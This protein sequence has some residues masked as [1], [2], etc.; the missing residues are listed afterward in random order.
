[1]SLILGV[2]C[3]DG[4]LAIADRRTHIRCGGATR[5]RD[6]YRKLLRRPDRHGGL[7]IWNHGYNRIGNKDWKPRAP[8]LAPD[9]AHPLYATIQAEIARKDAGPAFYVFMGPALLTEIAIPPEGEVTATDLLPADRILSGEGA[10]HVDLAPLAALPPLKDSTDRTRAVARPVLER[11]FRDAHAAMARA[12]AATF[13]DAFD[14]L[15]LVVP[16][17]TAHASAGA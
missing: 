7:L 17:P 1:M 3:V 12:G 11:V 14:V 2:R 4:C 5:F 15:E 6:T 13:S 8:R 16:P 10:R 9:P